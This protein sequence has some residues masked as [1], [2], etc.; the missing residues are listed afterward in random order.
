MTYVAYI[1][2]CVGTPWYIHTFNSSKGQYVSVSKYLVFV[3]DDVGTMIGLSATNL[4][5]L[6]LGISSKPEKYQKNR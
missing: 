4:M 1:T 3:D 6:V 5:K 2:R